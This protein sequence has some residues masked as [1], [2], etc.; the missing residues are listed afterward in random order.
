[1]ER[2]FSRPEMFKDFLGS[3]ESFLNGFL[4]LGPARRQ[5]M[6]V[7][8]E[9]TCYLWWQSPGSQVLRCC[10]ASWRGTVKFGKRGGIL[11]KRAVEHKMENSQHGHVKNN[12][13]K[14]T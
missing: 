14:R 5:C 3:T 2:P 1:M 13:K 9:T 7:L 11:M 8:T 10:L 4:V 6:R 12:N